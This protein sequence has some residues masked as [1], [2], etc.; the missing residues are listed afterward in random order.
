MRIPTLIFLLLAVSSAI[1]RQPKTPR[2]E[3][4]P[5]GRIF[6]GKPTQIDWPPDYAQHEFFQAR[7][8]DLVNSGVNFAGH[9]VVGEW[10]CGTDC[11]WLFVLDM[12][13][14]KFLSTAPYGPHRPPNRD[15]LKTRPE[16]R[17]LIAS[18]CF[19]VEAQKKPIECGT[20]YFKFERQQFVTIQ[21][22][23]IPTPPY[24]R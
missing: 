19:N 15:W 1:P 9:Y 13:T 17:L 20:K 3:D 24:F 2:F 7:I 12:R 16:S 6:H 18:G 8:H 11:R 21:F 14:G 23:P 10:S 5:A 4:Y 22:D